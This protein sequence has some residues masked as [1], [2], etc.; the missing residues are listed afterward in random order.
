MEKLKNTA[1]LRSNEVDVYVMAFGGKGFTGMVRERMKVCK[2]LW[3]AGIKAEFSYKLK[4]KL[5]A[6]FKAADVN[7]V[8]FAV[9]LGEDEE[10][11]GKVK[12]KELGLP[13][14]HPEK[15][16]VMV[17][18]PDLVREVRSRLEKQGA[19]DSVTASMDEL[20]VED[21]K[22]PTKTGDDGV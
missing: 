19:T 6:Q 1:P 7:G 12:I 21:S 14:G 5:P 16:G 13:E 4:P 3:D 18:K 20:V 17:N 9:I 22:N 2:I 15:D 8:P 10:K 11:A